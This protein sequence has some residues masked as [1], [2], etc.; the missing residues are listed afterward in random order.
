MSEINLP[1]CCGD[2]IKTN[3]ER[4]R[5]KTLRGGIRVETDLKE[6]TVAKS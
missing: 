3:D 4:K 6:H 1:L 5:L 2:E